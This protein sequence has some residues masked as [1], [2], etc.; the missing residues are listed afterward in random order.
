MGRAWQSS[1]PNDVVRRALAND[2]D[3]IAVTDHN[4]AAWCDQVREATEGTELIALP[5]LRWSL[6]RGTRS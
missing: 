1:T 5:R 4:T 3:V 2:I 6:L